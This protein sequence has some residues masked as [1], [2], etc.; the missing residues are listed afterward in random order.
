MAIVDTGAELRA[1][2]EGR[3]VRCR[4]RMWVVTRTDR[5][6]LPTDELG[7]DR[8]GTQHV[9]TLASVEDD[10][11][12]EQIAVLWEAEPGTQV[13]DRGD[14]PVVTAD[15]F[16]S[17]E[18]FDA[19]LDAVRWGAITNADSRAL[20]APFRS[21]IEIEDHQLTPLARA[22]SMARVSLLIADD[23]GL[24][25]TIEAGLIAQELLLR[26]QADTMMVIC[27]PNLCGK[28]QREMSEKFGLRFEVIDSEAVKR[29]RRERGPAVNPF[30]VY[31]RMI[32]SGAWLKLP[33]QQA[34]LDEVV[35][36][37]PHHFPRTF[38]LLIVDEAHQAAP[39]AVGRYAQDSKYTQLIRRIVPHFEHRVF[40]TATPHNGYSESFEALLELVDSLRYSRGVEPDER[41]LHQTTMV[42][43]L[44]SELRD[45]LP[46]GPDGRKAFPERKIEDLKVTHPA[47]ELEG[48]ALIDRYREELKRGSTNHAQRAGAEFVTLLLKKRLLSSPDAFWKTINV[49][50]ETIRGHRAGSWDPDDLRGL[51]ERAADDF[52]GDDDLDD[53]TEGAT[54]A[55]SEA[56]ALSP[57]ADRLLDQL[58]SWAEHHRG[59]ADAKT[60]RLL[61]FIEDVCEPSNGWN[62]ERVIVFTEYRDTLDFLRALISAKGWLA[63]GRV[64]FVVGGIDPKK[65]A[66][67]IEEFNYDPA[68]TKV[69]VLIA[70]D[71]AS[72]GI[73][74]HEQCHRLVHMEVPFN[75][76]RLEQRNG[77]IDRHGQP[78]NEVLVYHFVGEDSAG[79]PVD[80]IDFLVRIAKKIHEIRDDLGS[81]S[82]VLASQIEQRLLGG[83]KTIDDGELDRRRDKAAKLL[84]SRERNLTR[85]LEAVRTRLTEST[86]ELGLSPE[87]VKRVVDAGLAITRQNPL[88]PGEVSVG[89]DRITEDIW[90]VGPLSDT[91]A[92]TIAFHW[93]AVGE[94]ERPITFTN[95]VV[96]RTK[97]AV[98]AHL[99]HPL[100][101]RCLRLLRS[102]TW[103]GGSSGI[104]RV[105][106][107]Y[108]DIDSLTVA[109]HA[110]VVITGGDGSRLHEEVVP[111]A[112]TVLGPRPRALNVGETKSALD[113]AT[114]EQ[115]PAHVLAMLADQWPSIEP[116]VRRAITDRAALVAGQR[117]GRLDERRDQE[118]RTI[119]ERLTDLRADL[120][121]SLQ[122][123][124]VQQLQFEFADSPRDLRQ[125]ERN[126]DAMRTRLERIPADIVTEQ[127]NIDR[128]YAERT[129]FTFPI[130]ITFLVPRNLR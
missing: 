82:P 74:L 19:Y 86:A 3:L 129:E 68:H 111:V 6:G 46:L 123:P 85:E 29:I 55:A 64:E 107:R 75:P 98:Y 100:V 112:V 126:L 60:T 14:L 17:P 102:K 71:T 30:V 118:R 51:Y 23:V 62:D 113:A 103:E 32:V 43:R 53:A 72:E 65:R 31:P 48:L 35:D 124:D 92:D 125:V 58:I 47:A 20:Q 78:A 97:R 49:H 67:I 59:K 1:P 70:T 130:A 66:R 56:S 119:A 79:Q 37:D 73:D 122:A 26:H 117:N 84:M 8:L 5:S 9:V 24:G 36:P 50:A 18:R 44:K 39:A 11:R 2:E 34:R 115:P 21:G 114:D 120:E 12:G 10:A 93:D 99:G 101:N 13:Y 77:R 40:L 104:H 69:R 110:R 54:A 88:R 45:E 105:T 27:P 76:N 89:T 41:Q 57:E 87:R 80:D 22:L 108:A 33:A 42:R 61:E 128:R 4:G 7:A 81:A 52:A 83:S 63:D 127:A 91:W 109:A 38:D 25:K 94:F 16:D 121:R 90:E 116:A 95:Q 96:R 106:A 15:G 28:W